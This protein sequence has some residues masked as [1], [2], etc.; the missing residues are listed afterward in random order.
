VPISTSNFQQPHL[1]IIGR[2]FVSSLPS[3]PSALILIIIIAQSSSPSIKQPA[4]P[5]STASSANPA[6]ALATQI[7]NKEKMPKIYRE[8]IKNTPWKFYF[9]FFN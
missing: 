1:I 7:Q 3:S 8:K 9:W 2:R 6:Q 4:K 5:N